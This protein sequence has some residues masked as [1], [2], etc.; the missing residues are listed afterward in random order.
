MDSETGK[1]WLQDV[2]RV[3][4]RVLEVEPVNGYALSLLGQVNQ[5]QGGFEKAR[6]LYTRGLQCT[7]AN[8]LAMCK[9]VAKKIEFWDGGWGF[10]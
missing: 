3:L 5:D 1:E 7:G 2:T 10:G 4:Q 6:E 8:L 9:L